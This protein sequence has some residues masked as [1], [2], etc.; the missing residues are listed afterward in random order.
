MS[1]FRNGSLPASFIGRRIS[2]SPPTDADPTACYESFRKHW[3]QAHDIIL[4]TQV[5]YENTFVFN[6]VIATLWPLF[7]IEFDCIS[8]II[9]FSDPR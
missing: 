1:W 8:G 6:I 4:R 2:N 5:I 7:L 3:Q 9:N